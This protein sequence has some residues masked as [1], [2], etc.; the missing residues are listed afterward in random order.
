[1]VIQD[2]G[3]S[4]S[5]Q[6]CSLQQGQRTQDIAAGPLGHASELENFGTV[7]VS[8]AGSASPRST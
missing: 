2:V 4:S 3:V 6:I 1:M 7:V 8:A 5:H